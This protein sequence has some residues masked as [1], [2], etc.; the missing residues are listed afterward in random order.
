MGLHNT[1]SRILLQN[2]VMIYH[3]QGAGWIYIH[4]AFMHLSHTY[5]M[6][7]ETLAVAVVA[8]IVIIGAGL[9]VFFSGGSGSQMSETPAPA[10]T[11][12]QSNSTNGEVSSSSVSSSTESSVSTST[13][14]T[15]VQYTDT[16]FSPASLT[17]KS[18]Q[19]VTFVNRSNLSMWIASDPHP[20]HQ[21]Y[22]GTTFAAHCAAGYAGAKPFDQCAAGS[23]FTFTFIKAGTWGYHNHA[24]FSD[25]G[26]IVVTP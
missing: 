14:G 23:T 13:I 24:A 18:G 15:T 11:E 21:G 6:S 4:Q 9:F 19:R 25:R 1:V 3:A 2:S 10:P 17:V 12:T 20:M 22:D 26:T 8:V 7:N 16:G 5:E